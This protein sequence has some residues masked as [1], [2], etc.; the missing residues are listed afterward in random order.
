MLG[1]PVSLSIS[2]RWSNVTFG[3]FSTQL[4]FRITEDKEEE[5]RLVLLT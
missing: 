1:V 5:R 3:V 4:L 2:E